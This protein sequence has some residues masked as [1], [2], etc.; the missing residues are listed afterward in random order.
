L[1]ARYGTSGG[2]LVKK[3][4]I[5]TASEHGIDP[6][7]IDPDAR[8][9]VSRLRR[10]GF[11]AY[12]VGG[13]IR[14][15]LTGQ[16]PKDFDIATDAY[17]RR[18]RRLFRHSRIIGRR[19]RLVHVYVPDP[20]GQKFFEVTTF[21]ASQAEEGSNVYGTIEEDVWRRDFT[22]NALYY[23]PQDQ[24]IID[25][26]GGVKDIEARRLRT[27]VPT[28]QSF[29]ED[30]VRMIRGV[31]YGEMTGFPLPPAI[32]GIIRKHR[33]ELGT[34]SPARLTEEVYKILG[35]GFAAAIMLRAYQLGLLE[36]FLPALDRHLAGLGRRQV[37]Q[38]LR[39][40]LG[41]LDERLR[42]GG[43]PA[44]NRGVMLAFLLR[45]VAV[46]APGREPITDEEELQSFLR[47]AA[48]PLV[49][50]RRELQQA[51]RHLL[52]RRR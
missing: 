39:G 6:G 10:A 40:T 44:P 42:S 22:V 25:F 28:E 1:L 8:G 52:R 34:C 48:E 12:I 45:G 21:R 51:V 7:L 9:I 4:D 31:K 5:Y 32:T 41:V 14:D 33:R 37:I 2:K 3:A 17:P 23:C 27:L 11:K 20:S 38:A 49:P 19:F 30:P 35:S 24:I 13:A 50:S 26:V 15:L 16:K 29:L 36:V 18:I 43:Q 46:P 47:E